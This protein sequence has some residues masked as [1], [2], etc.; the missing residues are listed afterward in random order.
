VQHSCS[1]THLLSLR[2]LTRSSP[3]QSPESFHRGSWDAYSSDIYALGII[4]YMLLSS[5]SPLYTNPDM[6]HDVWFRAIFTGAWL[7]PEMME[8]PAAER[9]NNMPR[10]ALELIDAIIKPQA[11]RPTID[12]ILA[13]PFLQRRTNEQ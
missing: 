10:E 5:G 11:M 13:S 3:A 9:Y 1:Y 7:T 12:E 6:R 2:P 8:Q 4:L